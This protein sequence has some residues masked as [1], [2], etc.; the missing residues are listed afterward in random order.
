MKKRFTFHLTLLSCLLLML[1]VGCST[2]GEDKDKVTDTTQTKSLPK[3][4]GKDGAEMVLIPAGE[5]EMG[6]P[7]NE[8]DP[9]ERPVHTVYLDA[10][11][12]D[13]YEV[14]NAQYK[15]FSAL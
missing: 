14:T 3:I 11:H 12:M 15:K 9:D 5:F 2:E 1:V 7:F 10:F 13:V 8:G 4:T 6:D